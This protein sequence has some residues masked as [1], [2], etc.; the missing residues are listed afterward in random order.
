M[1]KTIEDWLRDERGASAVE[2]AL[3]LVPLV[4]LLFGIMHLFL[5]SYS[6]MQLN[7]AAEST[8]R[9]MVTAANA[10]ANG[11]YVGTCKNATGS[12]SATTYFDGIYHGVTATPTLAQL[13]ETVTCQTNGTVNTD[14]Q[15]VATAP[16]RI[17]AFSVAWTVTLTAKACFPHS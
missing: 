2:L 12:P 3:L 11:G 6:A 13:D 9:C 10:N 15:V 4:L 8:A 14:Y 16:Y 1:T 5:L 17:N 7:Y